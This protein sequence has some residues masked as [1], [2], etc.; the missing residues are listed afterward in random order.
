MN[1]VFV[2]NFMNHHQKPLCDSLAQR[3]DLFKF[4]CTESMPENVKRFGY[5][6]LSSL[7]YV[8]G[9]PRS[10][11]EE[12][13]VREIINEADAVIFGSCP[14]SYVY[15]RMEARRLSFIFSERLWK[16]GTYRRFIPQIRVR[17]I[18]R[19]TRYSKLPL[20]TLCSSCFLT[21][22]LSL[23]DYPINKCYRWGYFTAVEDINPDMVFS[24]KNKVFQLAWVGRFI[25]LKRCEDLLKAAAILKRRGCSFNIKIVGAGESLS[26]YEQII[27]R[28]NLQDRI[29]FCGNMPQKEVRNVMRESRALAFTSDFN[30]GWGAVVNEAM[31]SVCVPVL[32]HAVGSSGFLVQHGVNGLI[33]H[34]G[35]AIDLADKIQYLIDNPT[36]T[37]EMALR[38][39]KKVAEVY[40]GQVAAERL[41][42]F[43]HEELAG[44][45]HT[46]YSDGPMSNAP[47]MKNDWVKRLNKKWMI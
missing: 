6:D 13:L 19:F 18:N 23:I 43:I 5:D 38:S 41:M 7:P 1:I 40:N 9:Y 29:F 12:K 46:M 10:D 42:L 16:K 4:I 34:M 27:E 2:S 20:Y 30:E 3:C 28:N 14:D 47:I 21:Y 33:Y 24:E 44:I 39:Y 26:H 17:V 25:P 35:D 31:S 32:S 8:V 37:K 11:D 36:K 15:M 22:D 45:K